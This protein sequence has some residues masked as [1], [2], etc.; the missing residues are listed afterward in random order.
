MIVNHFE[1]ATHFY[2]RVKSYLLQHEAHHNLILGISDTL[3]RSPERFKSQPYLV[4]VEEDETLL[5]IALW[6]PPRKLVLSRSVNSLAL[7]AIAQDLH[8]RQEQLPGAIGPVP[9]AK[10][11]AQSWQALTGQSYREDIAQR[12]YQLEA[13]QPI[14]KASGNFRQATTDD[15]DLV[16][17]WCKAFTEE[18]ID[19]AVDQQQTER[20]V[21]RHLSEETLYLWQ[22]NVPV[23]MAACSGPTPN[24]IRI[25]LVYT[26]PEHRKKGYASSCVAALSQT[27]LDAGRKYCFLFT[28]LANSTSNHIYQ[29]IGYQPVCDVNDYSFEG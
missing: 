25:N 11:F 22:D 18:A 4:S 3:I 17:G 9:E 13:V 6:T 23:S 28:D 7:S 16:I 29:T 19:E 14:P 1:N 12:I 20:L 27:L 21:D 24:G 2:E 26:P 10:A 5:A 8:S 15:R